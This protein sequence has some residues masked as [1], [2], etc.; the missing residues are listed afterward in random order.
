MHLVK[1]LLSSG[2]VLIM[3]GRDRLRFHSFQ[4]NVAE[5]PHGLLKGDPMTRINL[6]IRQVF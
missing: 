6:T 3:A 1:F 5:A 2:D 4:G